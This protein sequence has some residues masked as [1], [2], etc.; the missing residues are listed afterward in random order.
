MQRNVQNLLYQAL[1]NY[2]QQEQ[3]R[4]ADEETFKVI[5]KLAN[6]EEQGYL[7]ADSLKTFPRQDLR[8]IDRLWLN[9]SNGKV[10]T[11]IFAKII[12]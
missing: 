8:T 9:Y 2:L 6:R 10:E 4:K 11:F 1:E 3:W 5:L 7:D 12:P